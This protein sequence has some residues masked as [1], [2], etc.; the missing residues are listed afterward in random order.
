[1]S[2]CSFL[3][4]SSTSLHTDICVLKT[5]NKLTAC[6]QVQ[7]SVTTNPNRV[8]QGAG[9][10]TCRQR[11]VYKQFLDIPSFPVSE[12]K[13]CACE[14]HGWHPGR[15]CRTHVAVAVMIYRCKWIQVCKGK[16]LSSQPDWSWEEASSDLP[17]VL[18]R[19]NNYCCSCWFWTPCISNLTANS[20]EQSTLI[21]SCVWQI[22]YTTFAVLQCTKCI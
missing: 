16:L 20:P 21:L 14:R 7:V 10:D 12:E 17:L 15:N 5:V 18:F 13:G 3:P 22:L 1:M 6:A 2:P 19:L 11:V 9:F 8:S 4:Q